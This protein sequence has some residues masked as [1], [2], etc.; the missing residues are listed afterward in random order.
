SGYVWS[1]N[2]VPY[3]PGYAY[4]SSL[5]S[6]FDPGYRARR[7]H[8]LLST[9]TAV[10]LADMQAF[11]LDV[12]DTAAQSLVPYV[13]AAVHPSDGVDAQAYQALHGW[14]YNMTVNSTAASI[15]Y[16]FMTYYLQDTYGDEYHAA[17][18]DNLTLP[19]FNTLENLTV[20]DPT[21]H[22]FD[23]VSG[24]AVVVQGRDQVIRQAFNDT[25]R[26]LMAAMG[27]MVANW[28]W[29]TIHFREFDHLSG[30]S[31]LQRGP[32]PAG[33]DGFTLNVAGGLISKGGPSWRQIID[34]NNLND[35]LAI[36]PG[37]QSGNP[38]SV[39]YDDFL[40]GS[41][42]SG[43]YLAFRDEPTVDSIP[44]ASVESTITLVPG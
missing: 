3:P 19:Q 18:A 42:L 24:G 13:L 33:G 29:G 43:R 8:E 30:L 32:Y 16:T 17:G 1:N 11:Q 9:T 4:G 15:W 35:S 21:S 5:G 38:L 20:N 37:G 10:T 26:H 28:E 39:H 7:I 44:A 6:L 41:Y 2:Q 27:P 36:Y 25:V 12:L 34:F 40:V 23:N 14:D 31:A 22:W